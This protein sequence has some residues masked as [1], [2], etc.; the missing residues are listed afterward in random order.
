MT[1]KPAKKEKKV[2]DPNKPKKPGVTLHLSPGMAEFM[3]RKTA[4]RTD[5]TVKI[6]AWIKEKNLQVR[7]KHDMFCCCL[8]ILFVF[9]RFTGSKGR[10]KFA[11]LRRSDLV[12]AVAQA[13]EGGKDVLLVLFVCVLIN[14]C[15]FPPDDLVQAGAAD[16]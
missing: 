1:K 13:Q 9:F 2:R 4:T 6:R 15:L 14:R 5:V 10:K 7:Q 12:K 8:F 16:L 11:S 3:G